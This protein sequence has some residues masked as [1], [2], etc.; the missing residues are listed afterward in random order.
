MSAW[1]QTFPGSSMPPPSMPL[2]VVLSCP[3]LSC[4][5]LS[6]LDFFDHRRLFRVHTSA[7]ARLLKKVS[8]LFLRS[9]RTKVVQTPCA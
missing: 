2:F 6:V 8:A 9:F 1:R 5:V 3:V 4:P 7:T